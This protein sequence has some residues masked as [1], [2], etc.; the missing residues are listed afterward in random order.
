MSP[1]RTWARARRPRAMSTGTD[2]L[3]SS[4]GAPDY[5]AWA[6]GG[7]DCLPGQLHT[8]VRRCL[9]SSTDLQ[10]RQG[11]S[12][13]A[14]PD[15]WRVSDPH[16]CLSHRGRE[17]ARLEVEACPTATAFGSLDCSPTPRFRLGGYDR[18]GQRGGD[19][20]PDIRHGCGP[21]PLARP[22]GV[23]AAQRGCAAHH[24]WPRS[25]AKAVCPVG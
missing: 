22:R 8:G 24:P 7:C 12:P 21:L 19:R 17:A 16:E 14:L 11:C 23:R 20:D 2:T 4:S 9:G 18:H 3:M 6:T 1:L 5:S 10:S 15:G 13:G 25:M